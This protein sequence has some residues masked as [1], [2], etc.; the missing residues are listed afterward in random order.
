MF[1]EFF[2]QNHIWFAA[3]AVILVLLV[4]SFIQGQ[5]KGAK[6][7]SALELPSLQRDGNATIIDVNPDKDFDIAHIPDALNF[8]IDTLNNDNKALLKLKDHTAIVTCQTGAKSNKAAKILIE[9]GF[10]NVHILRGG[11]ISWTKENL[12]ITSKA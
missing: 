6:M 9:L 10:T 5:V 12:P 2:A 3:L 11:L 8:P 1:S 4:L 7:V